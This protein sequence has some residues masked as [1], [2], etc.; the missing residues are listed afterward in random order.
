MQLRSKHRNS[1]IN[2]IAMNDII[3]TLLK[4][5]ENK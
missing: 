4:Y 1:A 5:I 3:M 2:D